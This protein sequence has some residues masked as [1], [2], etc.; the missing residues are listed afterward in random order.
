[1]AIER[2]GMRKRIERLKELAGKFEEGCP[3]HHVTADCS[4]GPSSGRT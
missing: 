2:E 1:M 3:E 4:A